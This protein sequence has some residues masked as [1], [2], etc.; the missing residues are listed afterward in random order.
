MNNSPN[1]ILEDLLTLLGPSGVLIKP[2]D[3]APYLK[4]ER[5]LLESDCSII[6]RPADTT[7]VSKAVKL[8]AKYEI[9]IVP[10]GGNTGLGGGGI[11]NGGV[12]LSLERLNK[13]INIDTRCWLQ[14]NLVI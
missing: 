2:E 3:I 14:R 5:G 6:L 11:A 4:E 7:E 9:P 1:S 13:I 8:C 12:I 10:L